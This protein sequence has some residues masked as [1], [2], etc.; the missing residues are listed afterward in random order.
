[1]TKEAI[2]GAKQGGNYDIAGTPY[3]IPAILTLF[4]DRNY[5]STPTRT[6]ENPTYFSGPYENLHFYHLQIG[7]DAWK[8][9]DSLTPTSSVVCLSCHSV[10][11]SNTQWG[12]VHDTLLFS[13]VTGSGTEQYGM[14]GAALNSLGNY[15]TSC[16]FNC[17]PFFGTTHSWFEPSNE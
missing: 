4:R 6:Y 1:V 3:Y 10:H 17:H 16:A 11:G 13:H 14:I 8:Y 7:P 2:L 12:W 5:V 15:P 9:R